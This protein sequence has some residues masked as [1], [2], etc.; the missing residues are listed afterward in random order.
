[1]KITVPTAIAISI[2]AVIT[3]LI[4]YD[5]YSTYSEI[6]ENRRVLEHL[7]KT[8]EEMESGIKETRVKIHKFQTDPRAAEAILRQKFQMLKKDQFIVND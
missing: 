6:K 8:R 3:V 7:E 1:L 2:T 5:A 4:A